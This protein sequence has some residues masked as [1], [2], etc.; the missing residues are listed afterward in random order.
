MQGKQHKDPKRETGVPGLFED[1]V[2]TSPHEF[3]KAVKTMRKRDV[4]GIVWKNCAKELKLNNNDRRISLSI[5]KFKSQN[6]CYTVRKQ[7]LQQSLMKK[8]NL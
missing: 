3:C 8:N 4:S 5:R 2:D 7:Q 1:Q 6:E